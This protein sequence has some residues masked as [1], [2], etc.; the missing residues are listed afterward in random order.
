MSKSTLVD[1]RAGASGV[2]FSVMADIAT[3]RSSIQRWQRR[4][5]PGE[6]SDAPGARS[7]RDWLVDSALFVLAVVGGALT[8]VPSWD[9]HGVVLLVLD[10]A[11]GSAACLA[12]WVRR[13]RPVALGVLTVVA[14]AFSALAA[15]AALFA[16]FGVALRASRRALI[17]IS[18]LAA[19]AIVTVNLL[20]P[21]IGD[22][23]TQTLLG[24]L[25][26][27]VAV[28]LGLFARVRRELVLSL[29]E[30]TERLEAEQRLHIE[31]AREAERR[32][33]AREMH[34]VL[35]HRL[36]LL[37]VH[38]G[39]LEFRPDASREELAE[40]AEVIR[41][42]ARA[43]L[44][45]LREVIGLLRDDGDESVPQPPQPTFAEIPLLVDESRTAGMNVR[46]QDDT[47][48]EADLPVAVGRTA[49][50]VVQEG[51][52]NARKHAPG[53]AV[54]VRISE[55]SNVLT[56]EVV[57]RPAVGAAVSD[58]L[59]EAGTGT[60]LIGLAER[61]A[62]TGGELTYGPDSAGDFVLRATLRWPE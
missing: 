37:T 49:Y 46:L 21:S 39:A 9:D 50:R 6:L 15:L 52:T 3:E 42:S 44:Q 22:F 56:V 20:Y 41:A 25:C 30:R 61:V 1:G 13:S 23:V 57:N 55:G 10:I 40:A 62:L 45:E 7:P 8:L 19:I 17:G 28:S 43:A 53:A 34:D 4:L 14:G 2:R 5:L 59:A 11:A 18:A 35:A 36:S 51:L 12:L 47:S 60:G 54:E 26:L 27:V 58:Q 48:P 38:A 31:Q 33:I 16:V 24:W 32:R 29:R